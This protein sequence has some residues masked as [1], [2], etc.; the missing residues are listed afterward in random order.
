MCL[1]LAGQEAGCADPC[2]EGAASPCCPP[3]CFLCHRSEINGCL[4]KSPYHCFTQ[5]FFLWFC[6][7]CLWENAWGWCC[8]SLFSHCLQLV[9][10]FPSF[11][12]SGS[13]ISFHL[14][15]WT[16]IILPVR[17]VLQLPW[18]TNTQLLA[19]RWLHRENQSKWFVKG[20]QKD[21][22]TAKG[23]V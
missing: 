14:W 20:T 21:T 15:A 16:A 22:C 18:L 1:A 5:Q 8:E 13:A 19:T 4:Q 11:I 6:S 9:P 12:S 17:G 10:I 23:S 7:F 2:N 3:S